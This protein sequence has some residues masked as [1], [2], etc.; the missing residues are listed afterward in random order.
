MPLDAKEKFAEQRS[1]CKGD[2][3][4]CDGGDAGPDNE[5]MPLPPPELTRECDGVGAGRF[6][7]CFRRER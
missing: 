4:D 6:E 5:S 3:R 1:Q 7:E 2:E